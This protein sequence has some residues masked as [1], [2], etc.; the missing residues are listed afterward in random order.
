MRRRC[1]RASLLHKVRPPRRPRSS[2]PRRAVLCPTRRAGSRK[3]C[4][5]RVRRRRP[6]QRRPRR[7]QDAASLGWCLPAVR[8]VLLVAPV[9]VRVA[10]GC[11]LR[12][13][14]HGRRLQRRRWRRRRRV[15][16]PGVERCRRG[17]RA[18]QLCK[19]SGAGTGTRVGS[20]CGGGA[21]RVARSGGSVQ[22]RRRALRRSAQRG[23]R[24]V[25]VV[26]ACCP[27]CA[28]KHRRSRAARQLARLSGRH[29]SARRVKRRRDP[30]GPKGTAQPA[31]R[32][33]G[34]ASAWTAGSAVSRA[35]AQARVSAAVAR[36]ER[37]TSA[38]RCASSQAPFTAQ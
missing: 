16:R 19:N 2:V 20:S 9:L 24:A 27:V 26:A 23:V 8:I 32:T 33:A 15:R 4:R 31:A 14:A 28:V 12:R 7:R 38:N 22:A 11:R 36:R 17:R 1:P 6:R 18:A 3:V 34:V 25:S 21:L 29:A 30:D 35:S 13:C 37:E 10:T 5:R